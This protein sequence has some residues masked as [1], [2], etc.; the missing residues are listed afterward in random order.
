MTIPSKSVLVLGAIFG[1]GCASASAPDPAPAPAPEAAAAPTPAPRAA[2]VLA[3]AT[4]T[5]DQADRGRD[6]F[7]AQCTECHYS[8]EFSDSQFKFKWSRRSAGNLYELIQTSMPET[9]PGSLAPE[10]AV[11]LVSYIMRMNG[12]EPGASALP[13]DREVLD[14]ISLSAIRGE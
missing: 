6:T 1:A 2:E 13:A 14:A 3:A 11:E 12:F 4:F 5:E 10:E 8:S 7:R 9:A